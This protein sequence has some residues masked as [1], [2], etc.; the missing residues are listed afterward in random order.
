MRAIPVRLILAAS[1]VLALLA[2][3][4]AAT[5]AYFSNAVNG[6]TTVT[7]ANISIGGFTGFPLNFTN[8]LP[9]D[10]QSQ[11]TQV[12]NNG[13]A[14]VDLYVQLIG[15]GVGTNF[16][17]TAG[18]LNLKVDWV[19][20]ATVYNND[21][22]KLY[23][24]WSGSTIVKVADDIGVGNTETFMNYLTL[25]PSAGNSYMNASN[26]GDLIRMIAVQYNGPAPVPDPGGAPWPAGD[27]NYIP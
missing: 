7:T 12:K 1:S 21:I 26:T 8:L 16:C 20:H 5:S 27:P 25:A 3:T 6:S 23:P 15:D 17:A 9:G 2:L 13:S 18:T 19:G 14:K 10:T 11:Q 22:C 24:G 4:Y